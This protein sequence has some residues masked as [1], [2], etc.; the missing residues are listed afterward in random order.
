MP[1]FVLPPPH[2]Y[3]HA[4]HGRVIER[5]LPLAEARR[6]CAAMGAPA[7][8]CAWVSKGACHIVVPRNGPVHGLA[9]YVRHERAHCNGWDHSGSGYAQSNL[10]DPSLW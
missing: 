6:V 5:V 8:A 9:P 7:D 2:L 10:T 4:Y 1:L 3:D